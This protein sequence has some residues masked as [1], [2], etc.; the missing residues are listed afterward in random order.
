MY[1]NKEKMENVGLGL[2]NVVKCNVM[3]EFKKDLWCVNLFWNEGVP[4]Y[5]IIRSKGIT[6]N[7]WTG[8]NLK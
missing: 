1:T 7:W 5:E 2:L 4:D 6:I 3:F 8:E